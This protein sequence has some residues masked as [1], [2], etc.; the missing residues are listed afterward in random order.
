MKFTVLVP[1]SGPVLVTVITAVCDSSSIYAVDENCTLVT[2][3]VGETLG[4]GVG[5][6]VGVGDGVGDA[7]TVGVGDGVPHGSP[8]RSS[9]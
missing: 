2:A 8:V 3:G 1:P 9:V 6:T 5:M 4:V 7:A